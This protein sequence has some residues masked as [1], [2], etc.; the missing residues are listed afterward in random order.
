MKRLVRKSIESSYD[1]YKKYEDRIENIFIVNRYSDNIEAEYKNKKLIPKFVDSI[2]N[3]IMYVDFEIK[4]DKSDSNLNISPVKLYDQPTELD[5]S[6]FEK[7]NYIIKYTE[8]DEIDLVITS[9]KIYKNFR[10]EKFAIIN[11]DF[12]FNRNYMVTCVYK[13]E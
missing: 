2:P 8:E 13:V 3:V 9:M 12:S 7:G 6:L 11:N 1:F 4:S 5:I 10:G